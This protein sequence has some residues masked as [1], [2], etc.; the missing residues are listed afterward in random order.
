MDRYEDIPEIG[1]VIEKNEP[2]QLIIDGLGSK[3]RGKFIEWESARQTKE[4]E[5]LDNLRAFNGQYTAKEE[6]AM[7][8]NAD[9]STIFVG[10]TRMKC[11]AAYS[12]ITDLMFQ[13][14]QRF[15]ELHPTPIPDT[16]KMNGAQRLAQQEIQN[17]VMQGGIDA[18]TV[19]IDALVLERTAEMRADAVEDANKRI[20]AMNLVIEDQ[21][22]ECKA[23]REIKLALS[24]M[25]IL[26]DG[27]IKGAT[28]NVKGERKWQPSEGADWTLGYEEKAFPDVQFRS[29]FNIYPDPF[30]TSVDDMTGLF[31]RHILTK[32]EFKKLTQLTDAGF[33]ADKINQALISMPGGNHNENQHESERRSISGIQSSGVSGRYEVLEYWGFVSGHDLMQAG[34]EIEDE[35]TEYQANVWIVNNTVIKAMLNPL[36]PNRIPYQIVPYEFSTHSFWGTGIPAM[37][38]DSQKVINASGRIALDN[39]AVSSGPIIE[40]NTDMLP[41]GK[42]I[43]DIKPWS[44][45]GR[46][47]GDGSQPMLRFYQHPNLSQPVMAL[48]DTFRKFADEETSM[49][50]YSHGQTQSGMTKTASGMSMLMGA[51]NVSLKS[52]IKNIDDY[53]IEPLMTSF[54]DW[55]MQWSDDESIKGD[56]VAVARGSSAL[57]MKEIKSER[58]MQFLQIVS[59]PMDAELIN[60]RDLL[61]EV[62][63]SLDLDPEDF[64]ISEK[65]LEARAQAMQAAAQSAQSAQLGGDAGI[66]QQQQ[67]A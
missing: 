64:L 58:L 47:G 50:S 18:A 51:A 30:A 37:M 39:A 7:S 48:M 65:E 3:L 34:L 42:T 33:D 43:A 66:T 56:A 54:Y 9:K 49:P 11:V 10:L 28:I 24:E 67:I 8:A 35:T 26:G 1:Q 61:S 59:N 36:M 21:L 6:A 38:K 16:E 45:V 31:D 52:V 15:G 27:C 63:T 57:M 29:I 53:L 55:N 25:V 46:A 23:E 20:D 44:V 14:G 32:S 5:W 41:P 4:Q 22:A 19:D 40:V 13:P 17:L 62:A 2:P 60:R 12:R